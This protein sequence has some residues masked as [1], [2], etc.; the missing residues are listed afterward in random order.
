MMRS[1]ET[2]EIEKITEEESECFPICFSFISQRKAD[3]FAGFWEAIGL[4]ARLSV[5]AN[6][7]Y[8]VTLDYSHE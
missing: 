4:E 2:E 1:I 3:R 8:L 6:G 7:A 5:A